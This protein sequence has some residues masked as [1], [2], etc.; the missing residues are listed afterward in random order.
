[1]IGG[2]LGVLMHGLLAGVW[3]GIDEVSGVF[4]QVPLEFSCMFACSFSWNCLA[5]FQQFPEVD[6]LLSNPN[7]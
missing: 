3:R 1:M 4:L 7:H 2:R 5:S 6:C